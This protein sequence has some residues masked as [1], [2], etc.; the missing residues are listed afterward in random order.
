MAQKLKSSTLCAFRICRRLKP[1]DFPIKTPVAIPPKL[2]S[3]TRPGVSQYLP[4]NLRS[5]SCKCCIQRTNNFNCSFFSA[6]QFLPAQ[7]KFRLHSRN[8]LVVHVISHAPATLAFEK[9]QICLERDE[10][11]E[12]KDG[13]LLSFTSKVTNL[14]RSRLLHIRYNEKLKSCESCANITIFVCRRPL[15]FYSIHV[16]VMLLKSNWTIQCQSWAS[17]RHSWWCIIFPHVD[18]SWRVLLGRLTVV[19]N[20]NGINSPFRRC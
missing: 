15:F 16:N 1:W 12:A 13:S 7:T 19:V 14:P 17:G 18:R 8:H 11:W 2:V 9:A 6:I 3:E 20:R 10:C 5:P 4:S